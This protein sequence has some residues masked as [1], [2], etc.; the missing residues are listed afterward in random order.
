MKRARNIIIAVFKELFTIKDYKAIRFVCGAGF[1]IVLW[2]TLNKYYSEARVKGIKVTSVVTGLE[3]LLHEKP[4]E[5]LKL[6]LK[7]AK[8]EIIKWTEEF[9]VFEII[10]EG[11]YDVVVFDAVDKKAKPLY[12]L[13]FENGKVVEKHVDNHLSFINT[14]LI[15]FK[16]GYITITYPFNDYV[17]KVIF[18]TLLLELFVM[19]LVAFFIHKDKEKILF[20]QKTQEAE[21]FKSSVAITSGIAHN[22]RNYLQ[23]MRGYL[24][25]IKR[26]SMAKPPAKPFTRLN[27]IKHVDEIEGIVQVMGKSIDQI[28]CFTKEDYEAKTIDIVEALDTSIN[29]YNQTSQNVQINF[30]KTTHSM[31]CIGKRH[32]FTNVF[33]NILNNAEQAMEQLIDKRIDVTIVKE[34]RTDGNWLILRFKDYGCGMSENTRNHIFEPFFT[35]NKARGTG[36]GMS[37]SRTIVEQY[38]G[39]IS[40]EYTEENK[41]TIIK[42]ELPEKI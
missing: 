2:F 17:S 33:Y 11:F 12:T 26:E 13:S 23:A 24:K 3:Y 30:D 14:G 29:M 8:I 10:P 9:R 32:L 19:L 16:N 4:D 37:T 41:G 7:D 40:V 18:P 22:F 35:V 28:L 34:R 38:N 31:F 5:A 25:M 15:E 21:R 27:T 39:I 1:L 36:L 6:A 20:I 42:I